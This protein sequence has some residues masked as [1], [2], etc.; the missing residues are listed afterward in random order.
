MSRSILIIDDNVKLCKSLTQNLIQFG[1]TCHTA[2][3]HQTALNVYKNHSIHVVLLDVVL[4][5]D[6]G[7]QV[8]QSLTKI[9]SRIPVIMITGYASIE[10]A[11]QSIKI[12][13]YD[14]IQKP[15]DF[16]KL[17]KIIENAVRLSELKEENRNLKERLIEKAPKIITQ[18]SR[19]LELYEKA[20]KLAAT[21]I[22]VLICGENGTGKEI[23]ADFIHVNSKRSSRKMLKTNCAAFPENLLDN[24]LFGHERGAYTGAVSVFKGVFERAHMSSLFLD[25]IGDMSLAIQ[26]K[27]LRVLQ[28]K[29]IR[30][31]GGDNVIQ[32]D[33]RFIAASNKILED[34]I[35]DN[36]F[37]KDLFYRLNAATLYIPPLRD[38]KDDIPLLANYF[39]KEF[40]DNNK[41]E[42]K[43]I[44]DDVMAAFIAYEWPGNVRHLKNTI[45][46]AAA[47][48]TQ[49]FIE[50]KDL[51][52][53]FSDNH[54]NG[55]DVNLRETTERHLIQGV[56]QN[57]HFNKKKAAEILKIT[58]K[59]LYN[60]IE[61]Y[62][63]EL[64]Q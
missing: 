18:N 34:L 13:A 12:G 19:M 39:L 41:C 58:R 4:G 40:T 2:D 10:S 44:S 45:Y 33:V 30:R 43:G 51:P 17:L 49:N 3:S 1:Y 59:T 11:V 20:K 8:L 32:V 57:T 38:R 7:L 23:I 15:L 26:A 42:I 63:I 29:E 21:D 5:K 25:E 53:P 50:S 27:I 62:G 6:D 46:Y 48:S 35:A 60:K 22:P 24:E 36:T 28:N 16:N 9:N 14:Y 55:T 54:R 31:I 52:A 64:P 47:I 37:R 56:L 61:K